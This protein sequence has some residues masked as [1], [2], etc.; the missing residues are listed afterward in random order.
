VYIGGLYEPNLY[1]L[2]PNDGDLKWACN[3]AYSHGPE[4][5]YM[6]G[7]PFPSPVIAPDGT[8]YQTLVH[9]SNL[10]AIA[11]DTGDIIWAKDLGGMVVC[12]EGL[13]YE[14]L[15]WYGPG[16]PPV[17]DPNSPYYNGEV[18]GWYRYSN[19]WSEPALALDGTIYVALDDDRLR[20][21]DPNGTIRWATQLG[22]MGNFT[23]TVCGDGRI[24]TAGDD[25]HLCVVSP[26]GEE[27]A[28]FRSGDWLTFPVIA[29]DNTIIVA[30]ERDNSTSVGDANNIVWA[31][32]GDGCEDAPTDL[33]SPQDISA[34]R[35]I[36]FRDFAMLALDWLGCTNMDL[37]A[38]PPCD[39]Q[40]YE[41]Y[42]A[43]D[44]N[45]DLYVDFS[46]VAEIAN[47]W[48]NED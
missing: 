13:I 6:S 46:D 39:Y 26:D 37:Y 2:E 45:K 9:D 8:I 30:G 24:Y 32:G 3:F 41:T 34:D 1:A 21:V 19:C 33:H 16:V 27:I 42:L 12:I 48:L 31:I 23:L 14:Y 47:R 4:G 25:G 7:W 38:D 17:D 28:R 40:G 22:M 44:I 35:I 18:E 10:Y 20:A 15:I 5:Y 43:G 29:A 36:N 11:P